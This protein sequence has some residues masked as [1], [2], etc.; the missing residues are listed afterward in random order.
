[1]NLINAL[2]RAIDEPDVFISQSTTRDLA[3]PG[4]TGYL[5]SSLSFFVFF[6]LSGFI[7]FRFFSFFAIAFFIIAGNFF[8]LSMIHLFLEST[9]ANGNAVKLFLFSGI[10]GFFHTILVPLGIMTKIS[11]FGIFLSIIAVT[12]AALFFKI[13]TIRRLYNASRSKAFWAISAPYLVFSAAFFIFTAFATA[14]FL[15]VI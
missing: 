2:T 5:A 13:W 14:W 15:W 12:T 9:G 7:P 11:Y 3:W 1:M 8:S 4:I 6:G 10:I